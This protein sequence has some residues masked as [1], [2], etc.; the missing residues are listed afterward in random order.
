MAR[1]TRLVK[2]ANHG[3]RPNSRLRR[4]SKTTR[5]PR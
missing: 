2:K 5:T 4:R 1:N 3:R